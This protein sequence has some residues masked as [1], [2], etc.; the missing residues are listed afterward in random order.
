MTA[1]RSNAIQFESMQMDVAAP[2]KR[3][4]LD[5]CNAKDAL[6]YVL[7]QETQRLKTELARAEERARI[8]VT[9]PMIRESW[10]YPGNLQFECALDAAALDAIPDRADATALV[11]IGSW[12][13]GMMT[14][15]DDDRLEPELENL[16]AH[17]GPE[18]VWSPAPSIGSGA[19]TI[20]VPCSVVRRFLRTNNVWWYL[21]GWRDYEKAR[22][23]VVLK[24]D[25]AHDQ[26]MDVHDFSVD[27][28]H[29][30]RPK[31]VFEGS[32]HRCPQC[33]KW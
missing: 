22:L 20:E 31:W 32:S 33:G 25:D 9:H 18:A 17:M 27:I 23:L 21:P 1:I 13:L 28:Y 8:G 10:V 7:T 5:E 4:A 11:T 29:R 6:L 3:R 14:Q 15:S 12:D 16:V 19:A 26:P 2:A 30:H 24:D